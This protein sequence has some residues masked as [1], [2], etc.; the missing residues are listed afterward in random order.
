VKATQR[1]AWRGSL[2]RRAPA[3]VAVA[4]VLL[5]VIAV[6]VRLDAPSDGTVVSFYRTDGVVVDVP[7]P[8]DVP[9]AYSVM[10]AGPGR[11]ARRMP[12]SA[13]CWSGK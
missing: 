10:D 1:R 7:G 5:G 2:A 4:L 12:A 6:A 13:A 8:G 9:A 3:I 11:N